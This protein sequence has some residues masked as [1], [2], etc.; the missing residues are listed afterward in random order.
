MHTA[1]TQLQ[2]QLELRACL[3]ED[4]LHAGDLEGGPHELG[5]P[6]EKRR[7]N[8]RP[9]GEHRQLRVLV[10]DDRRLGPR[11]IRTSARCKPGDEDGQAS[12]SG[13]PAGHLEST[14]LSM[15]EHATLQRPSPAAADT[16][17]NEPFDRRFVLRR[18]RTAQ[19]PPRTHMMQRL[20]P[21]LCPLGGFVSEGRRWR[22]GLAA[23]WQ[24]RPHRDAG[25]RQVAVLRG[26]PLLTLTMPLCRRLT[27]SDD[28]FGRDQ[29]W[30]PECRL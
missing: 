11:D 28:S 20:P 15:R 24:C 1:R 14:Q 27:R 23:A 8:G 2:T 16:A 25:A 4:A 9:R 26:E 22:R 10:D 19:R 7:M 13:P 18:S 12:W 17:S 3:Q 30:Q 21:R 6:V 5:D 29:Q